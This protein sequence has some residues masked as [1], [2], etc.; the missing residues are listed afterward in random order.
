VRCGIV[1]L[2]RRHH[3]Q[4]RIGLA[5]PLLGEDR[6]RW[7]VT[8]SRKPGELKVAIGRYGIFFEADLIAS[9]RVGNDDDRV[10]E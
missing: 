2:S 1:L 10:K 5:V 4:Q 7:F 9:V 3:H 8:G 6:R